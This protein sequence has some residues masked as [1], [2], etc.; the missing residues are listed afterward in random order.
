MNRKKS[1]NPGGSDYNGPEI[2]VLINSAYFFL[3]HVFV[4]K[5]SNTF[6]LM[7]VRGGERLVAN[8][9]YTTLKGAR[10]AYKRM[11]GKFAYRSEVESEWT[12]FYVPDG[13]WLREKLKLSAG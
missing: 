9:V 7:V 4:L 8:E 5:V 3:T 1:N 12:P 11:F 6:R 2:S 13:R 10:I